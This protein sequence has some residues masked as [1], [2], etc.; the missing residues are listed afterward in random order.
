MPWLCELD[1]FLKLNVGREFWVSG[2]QFGRARPL[3]LV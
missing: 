2:A 3:P 1:L